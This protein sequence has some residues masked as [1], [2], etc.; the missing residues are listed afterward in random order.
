M[1]RG[2][3]PAALACARV[4]LVHLRAAGTSLV[5]SADGGRLPSVVH[6]GA[7]LGDLPDEH[8]R[9]LRRAAEPGVAPNDLDVALPLG[10]LPETA[11]GWRGRPGLTGHREDGGGW[12]PSPRLVSWDVETDD[13]GG[14]RAVATGEDA[15]AELGVR[16]EVELLPAGLVRVRAAVR[17]LSAAGG[18][19]VDGVL[20]SLPV[21]EAATEVVDLA[22]RW[23]RERAP[24][25]VPF[26]VGA[27]ARENRR[28]RTGPDA[29]LV[30]TAGT[31]GLGFRSGEAWGVHVAWSGN[32]VVRAERTAEGARVLAGGELLLPGEVR[33]RPEEEHVS[34]WLYGSYAPDGLDGV[35]SRFHTHLRARPEHPR[36]PRPVV[37]NVWEAV[38]FDHDLERLTELAR[39]GAEVGAERFVLD[40]G[41]FRGRRDDTAG[42][43]DWYVDEDVWPD[44]LGPLVEAVHAHGMDFGLWFEP[45]MVNPD[46]DLARAHPDW[47]LRVGGRE[48]VLSRGQQVLDLGHPDAHAHVLG[49]L[50]ALL[51]E[52]D[53]AYVKW[54]H[55]RDVLDAGS[56]P[57]RAAGVHA[58]TAAVYALLDELRR[59]HP[60]VEVESCSSGGLRVDLG[61]LERTDRVWGS[62]CNDPLERQQIQRWTAQLLPPELVG[63][64]VASPR[65][66]TTGRTHDLSFRAGTALFG[67][68][69]VEWDISRATSGERAELARWVALYRELRGL[70]HTGAVVRADPVD[71]AVA[72]HGVVA[73]DGADALFALVQLDAPLTSVPGAVRLP[74]LRPDALYRVSAQAPGDAPRL[75]GGRPPWLDEGVVLP[76][77]VLAAAG[78]RAPAMDPEQLLL[79]RV[80]EV[81]ADG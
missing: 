60:G 43:G 16:V 37:L 41:W 35:A 23:A 29:P 13:A 30:M 26:A 79:L 19:V 25:R 46:S 27:H 38:Y 74:G 52:H 77:A 44:G 33:L 50:D 63:G 42:L 67:S 32:H 81:G 76:G 36:S 65:S 51:S 68:L 71:P 58:Q 56:G 66:H 54:D 57:A 73:A 53:I 20:P 11:T 2:G 4:D 22:G 69:G 70:L 5:L 15:D 1:A 8:L 28:G 10:L 3:S 59:R 61:V 49:R 9:A 6:W 47:L 17:D 21:P 48:P 45:E 24:Q 7:D 40:D 80:R 18:Y 72:L 12:S 14:G 78:V 34:P 39:L 55:N 75:R 31:A 64:H 62:D